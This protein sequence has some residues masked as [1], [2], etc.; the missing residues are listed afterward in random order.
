M[1]LSLMLAGCSGPKSDEPEL[2]DPEPAAVAFAQGLAEADLADSPIADPTE[3]TA[4]LTEV[5]A[6]MA[7]TPYSVTLSDVEIT[8]TEPATATASYTW[9][10]DLA[11]EEW[12]YSATAQLALDEDDSW[13][14]QW[15]RSAVEPSLGEGLVLDRTTIAA[16]RG[17]IL[18]AGGLALIAD[19]QVTRFG[20]DRTQVP[21]ER[22]GDSARKLAKLVGIEVQP[23]VERV[24][25]AGDQAYVEAIVYRRDEVPLPV[26]Q[27]Y[28]AIKGA[29]AIPTTMAL[30]P[31]PDF[32]LPI[33]GR[34]GEVTAEMVQ[35][36][37]ERYQAGDV[38][39][40]SGLEA[41]YDEQLTGTDGVVVHAIASDGKA[42][43]L[44][45][46]KAVDGEPLQLT[47]DLDIQLAAERALAEVGPS[48]ALVAIRPSTGAILAAA[49]G[50]GTSG[51]NVA[52]YGQVAPG[53]TFKVV[54]SL[55]LLRAGFTPESI[56]PCTSSITVDGKV[57]T[58]YDDFPS[59]GLG[60]VPLISAVANSCNTAFI[61]QY[62]KLTDDALSDA[63]AGLGFGVDHDAGFPSFFGTAQPADS[64]TEKAADLIGQGGILA[65]PMAMATVIASVQNGS[66]VI[67]RLVESVELTAPDGVEPVTAQEAAA[68]RRMLRA[69]VSS[70][71]GRGLADI[72]GPPVIAKTGTAEFDRE[73]KRLTHAWMVAAQGDL[74]VAV[75]VDVGD[76]GSGT[77][78]PILEEFLRAVR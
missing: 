17:D 44:I 68:L 57:F 74:A 54:S 58:N 35:E 65:S 70:G 40:L 78:G 11:P 12:T 38:A 72:P 45:R 50:P 47:M 14:I 41:R 2:P 19:R 21:A 24:E 73:G 59:S 33:L 48:S 63:A 26:A 1:L 62:S 32:A 18:G 5:I 55:A 53:S 60:N 9:T 23:Y 25:A 46:I 27:R 36:D 31:T 10:W 39:G 71:S 16:A 15:D 7:G 66:L 8:Q 61:S 34:V 43:Q 30:G 6:G 77:A 67:P 29:F 69:V 28:G 75:F 13:Q 22:A 37:P 20:I 56:L 51:F 76:S 49:N 42:R 64:K 3:A 4:E 52:T